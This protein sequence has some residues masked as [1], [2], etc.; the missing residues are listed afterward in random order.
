VVTIEQI[1]GIRYGA[2]IPWSFV[3]ENFFVAAGGNMVGGI[4]LV[5]LNRFTQARSGGKAVS[6]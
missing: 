1:Y 3:L 4:G 2:P 5:T 6:G